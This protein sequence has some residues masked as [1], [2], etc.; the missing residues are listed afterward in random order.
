M[1]ETIKWSTTRE[2]VLQTTEHQTMEQDVNKDITRDVKTVE[3]Q[4]N[5][6]EQGQIVIPTVQYSNSSIFRQLDIPTAR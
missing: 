1:K 6:G 5:M 4:T 2:S 3:R